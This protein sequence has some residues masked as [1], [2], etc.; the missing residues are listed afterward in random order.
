E[1][2]TK[3]KDPF[4]MD[5]WK[6]WSE[7][8]MDFWSKTLNTSKKMTE[9]WV[10]AMQS[11]S[12]APAKKSHHKSVPCCPPEQECPPH[13]LLEIDWEAHIGEVIIVPFGVKNHCG[14]EKTY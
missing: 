2:M 6:E 14:Q 4:G 13:C 10:S 12:Y 11:M 3:I 9:D 1:V 8:S 5:A 7:M